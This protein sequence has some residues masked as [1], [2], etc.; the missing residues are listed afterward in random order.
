MNSVTGTNQSA[1]PEPPENNR[2]VR[3]YKLD[4]L[5]RLKICAWWPFSFKM[6]LDARYEPFAFIEKA[7]PRYMWWAVVDPDFP[8]EELQL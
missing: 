1:E 5:K 7:E 3:N 6:A 2:K 8:E 4:Q